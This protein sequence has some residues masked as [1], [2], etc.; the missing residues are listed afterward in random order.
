MTTV[1]SKAASSL[2]PRALQRTNPAIR[3]VSQ[4]QLN[5]TWPLQNQRWN[6]SSTRQLSAMGTAGIRCTDTM[7]TSSSSSSIAPPTTLF[8]DLSTTARRFSSAAMTQEASETSAPP[9]RSTQRKTQRN[10]N[11]LIITPTA[12]SR[13]HFL[14]SQ[15]NNNNN[16]TTNSDSG[17]AIGIRLGTKKRGCNG[18]SYTLNYAYADH[19]THHPAMRS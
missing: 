14:I 18:L 7:F 8:C 19:S 9:P 11:P 6:P 3:R 13:I 10:R 2:L 15:H 16:D 12:A 1:P 17:A 4:H 5:Q